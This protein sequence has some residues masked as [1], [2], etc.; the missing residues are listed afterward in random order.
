MCLSFVYFKTMEKILLYNQDF[1]SEIKRKYG[2]ENFENLR[3]YSLI[4][5]RFLFYLLNFIFVILYLKIK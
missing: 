1:E 4:I 5:L 3:K 2:E